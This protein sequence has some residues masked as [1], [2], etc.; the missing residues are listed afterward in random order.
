[1]NFKNGREV[2][3]IKPKNNCS[4]YIFLKLLVR[5]ELEQSDQIEQ[6]KSRRK[7]CQLKEKCLLKK[8]H[9]KGNQQFYEIPG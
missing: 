6:S 2:E 8:D 4:G 9:R 1:M 7:Y 5:D 3:K